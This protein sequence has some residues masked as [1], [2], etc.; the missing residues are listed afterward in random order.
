MENEKIIKPKPK[1]KRIYSKTGLPHVSR[2]VELVH[3]FG[4]WVEC[5]SK[6]TDW[7]DGGWMQSTFGAKAEQI[8]AF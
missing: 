7:T 2:P 1:P 5:P 8:M 4:G 6:Q 3:Y